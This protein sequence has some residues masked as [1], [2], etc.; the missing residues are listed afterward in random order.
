MFITHVC[1]TSAILFTIVVI[2]PSVLPVVHPST[3]LKVMTE[4]SKILTGYPVHISIINRHFPNSAC[5]LSLLDT[6]K[7]YV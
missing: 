5:S 4:V 1:H 7:V 3:A 6:R 2:F